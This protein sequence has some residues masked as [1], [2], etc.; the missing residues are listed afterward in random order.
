MTASQS[1]FFL[2]AAYAEEELIATPIV[3]PIMLGATAVAILFIF[4]TPVLVC[5]GACSRWQATL[6]HNQGLRTR[7]VAQKYEL[8]LVSRRRR[9]GRRTSGGITAG[10]RRGLRGSHLLLLASINAARG[11]FQILGDF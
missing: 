6:F 3:S 11:D 5:S 2:A 1:T 4:S 9:G 8:L 7:R 10:L